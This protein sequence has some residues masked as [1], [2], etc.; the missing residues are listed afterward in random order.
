MQ[1]QPACRGAAPRPSALC[2]PAGTKRLL[3][4]TSRLAAA[5]SADFQVRS[6]CRGLPPSRRRCRCRHL[7]TRPAPSLLLQGCTEALPSPIKVVGMGSSGQD[8]LAQVR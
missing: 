8:L 1:P 4:M 2:V 7:P 3:R 6:C 5:T